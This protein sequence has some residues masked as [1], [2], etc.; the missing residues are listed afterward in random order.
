MIEEVPQDPVCHDHNRRADIQRV[1]GLARPAAV[2]KGA[3][4]VLEGID[5]LSREFDDCEIE[6][7]RHT[8]K[9][10]RIEK[11]RRRYSG[12]FDVGQ[13]QNAGKTPKRRAEFV[14][15]WSR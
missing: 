13:F 7:L 10:E 2:G 9:I 11:F 15:V 6:V 3:E 1:S 14:S 8:G 5:I 12:Y 4:E